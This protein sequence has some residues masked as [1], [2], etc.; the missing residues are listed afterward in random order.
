MVLTGSLLPV[1]FLNWRSFPK[2]STKSQAEVEFYETFFNGVT[3]WA[4]SVNEIT[5]NAYIEGCKFGL[6]AMDALLVAAAISAGAE[7]LIT[8]E[9]PERSIHRVDAINIL[10]IRPL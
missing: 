8:T 4:E 10:S 1:L 3:F 9:K 2:Q 5:K 7:E 6:N